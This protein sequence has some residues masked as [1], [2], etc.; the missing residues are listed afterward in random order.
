MDFN[1]ETKKAIA[2]I[3]TIALAVIIGLAFLYKLTSQKI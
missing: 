1:N 3:V 2:L